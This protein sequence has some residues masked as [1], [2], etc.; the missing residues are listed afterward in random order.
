[1]TAAG[2]NWQRPAARNRQRALTNWTIHLGPRA[3]RAD[4]SAAELI[5]AALAAAGAAGRVAVGG[6]PTGDVIVAGTAASN[7]WIA[8]LARSGAVDTSPVRPSTPA[9]GF[10]LRLLA[11]GGRRLLAVAGTGALGVLYGA[12]ELAARIAEAGTSDLAALERLDERDGPHFALRAFKMVPPLRDDYVASRRLNAVYLPTWMPLGTDF[13][14]I[15]AGLQVMAELAGVTPDDWPELQ[16]WE[17]R[18]YRGTIPAP[19]AATGRDRTSGGRVSK[20]PGRATRA[21]STGVSQPLR[22]GLPDPDAGTRVLRRRGGDQRDRRH[23]GD[24]ALSVLRADAP[25][26]APDLRAHLRAVPRAIGGR[27]LH[28]RGGWLRIAVPD[29]SDARPPCSA[30]KR[31]CRPVSASAAPGPSAAAPPCGSSTPGRSIW[32]TTR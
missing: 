17:Q 28:F 24:L 2:A 1:M 23:Q 29:A 6:R 31:S 27:R 30:T 25:D 20:P 19:A 7:P 32:S 18:S 11:E 14:G 21:G 10:H 12:D 8:D 13:A 9:E 4:R 15:H 26:R 5:D 22:M 3:T 16:W